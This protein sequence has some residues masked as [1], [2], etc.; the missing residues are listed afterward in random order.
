MATEAQAESLPLGVKPPAPEALKGYMDGETILNY[1]FNMSYILAW[2][3]CQT[4]ICRICC[5]I[6]CSRALYILG[7][8]PS[9]IY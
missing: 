2:Y 5:Q 9:S 1:I 6:G 4:S 8:S 7:L 3:Q